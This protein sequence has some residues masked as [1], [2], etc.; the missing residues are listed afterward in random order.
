MS[1]LNLKALQFIAVKQLSAKNK[2]NYSL[3]QI[4]R[5][6]KTIQKWIQWTNI[7]MW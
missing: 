4:L 3:Y 7:H 6:Y 2:H 5:L 1:F